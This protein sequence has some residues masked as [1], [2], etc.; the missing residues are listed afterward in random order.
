MGVEYKDFTKERLPEIQS[1]LTTNFGEEVIASM[2]KILDNPL[3]ADFPSSGCIGYRNSQPVCFKAFMLR[4]VYFGQEALLGLVGG[5]F[6]KTPKGCPLPVIIEVQERTEW[7]KNGCR[8]RFGNTCIY[9][10]MRLNAR[11]G[12]KPGPVSWSEMRFAVIRPISLI[13]HILRRKLLKQP[14]AF[15][16]GGSPPPENKRKIYA[17]GGKYTIRRLARVDETWRQFWQKYLAQNKG[18]VASRDQETMNWI[19]GEEI[20]DGRFVALGLVDEENKLAGYIILRPTKDSVKRWQILD[21]I[22]LNNS[23]QLLKLL[24]KGAR[25]FL[26]KDTSAMTLEATGFPDWVQPVLKSTLPFCRKTGHNRFEWL[27]EDNEL[28]ASLKEQG[29]KEEGWFFGPFDGDYFM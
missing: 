22:A 4:R 12:A 24:L 20:A 28:I 9:A 25:S 13:A 3:H 2:Q 15:E 19:F 6:C 11:L 7:N 21:M 26:K 8:F 29:N 10:T 17:T 1:L 5:F 16:V 23:R 14:R 27:A 18:I